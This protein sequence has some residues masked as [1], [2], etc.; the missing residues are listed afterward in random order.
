MGRARCDSSGTAT[1]G[2]PKYVFEALT[3]PH[4][5]PHRHWLQL[6]DDEVEPKIVEP[7]EYDVVVWSSI[8]RMHPHACVRFELESAG[9]GGTQLR[10][11]LMDEEDP[12]PAPVGHMRER[13]Q[14]LINAELRFTFGN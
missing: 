9:G 3:Q 8:W 5:D 11:I 10:W 7:S 6:L 2:P 12:G 13:I 14:Q 4:R 1:A